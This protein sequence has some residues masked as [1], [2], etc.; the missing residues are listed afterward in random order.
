[1]HLKKWQCPHCRGRNLKWPNRCEHCGKF[2]SSKVRSKK[3]TT[4]KKV[5]KKTPRIKGAVKS[6][7]PT[8]SNGGLPPGSYNLRVDI[9][10]NGK[11]TVVYVLKRYRS[12]VNGEWR[13]A[14]MMDS[15]FEDI[16]RKAML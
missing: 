2:R 13:P 14:V 3:R 9:A 12:C 7:P 11:P 5:A 6:K 15:K 1:M 8:I 16:L 10:D 4:R